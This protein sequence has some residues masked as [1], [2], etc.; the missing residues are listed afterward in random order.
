MAKFKLNG[1]KY[2]RKNKTVWDQYRE[3]LER[4]GFVIL[5]NIFP[6]DLVH[7]LQS[8]YDLATEK[9]LKF[10]YKLFLCKLFY[11]YLKYFYKKIK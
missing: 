7:K 6:L 8:A 3:E 2:Q 9:N 11:L 4:N 1:I 5:K 10:Y